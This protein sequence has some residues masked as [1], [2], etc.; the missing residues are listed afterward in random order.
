MNPNTIIN[1]VL[2]YNLGSTGR[3][4]NINDTKL[5]STRDNALNREVTRQINTL[6]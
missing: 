4:L 1:D 3:L 5:D 2:S 6:Y